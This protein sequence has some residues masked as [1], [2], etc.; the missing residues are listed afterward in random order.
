MVLSLAAC[1]P[2]SRESGAPP[3]TAEPSEGPRN[4]DA[5]VANGAPVDRVEARVTALRDEYGKKGFH[6]VAAHPWVV[7]GDEP[8]ELVERR[9]EGTVAWATERLKAAY[10]DED[11]SELVEIWLFADSKSYYH[12]AKKVF[13]DEPDTPFGY[14]TYE[15][16]ALI[17][18]I[19]SGGGT[20]VHEMVHPLM[21]SNFPT[22]PSWFNEGLASL[23]EQCGERDGEIVGYTNWRLAG[24]QEALIAGTVPSFATLLS[25]TENGFYREDPG[26]N[27]GQARYLCYWLQEQGTLRAFYRDFVAAAKTDPTGIAT[28]RE[29]VGTD[30]LQAFAEQWRRFVLDLRFEG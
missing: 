5:Q 28:L 8:P 9:A 7:I 21:R 15:H 26:T 30:D 20:L 6:V 14:Y 10:F 18:N 4:G 2:P 24:L 22:C 13:G 16:E 12:H 29:H 25:T 1:V 23:Y 17:M 11:P 27:Y 19:A 3:R